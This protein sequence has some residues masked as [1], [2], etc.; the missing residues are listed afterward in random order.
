[1]SSESVSIDDA[2]PNREGGLEDREHSDGRDWQSDLAVMDVQEYKQHRRQHRIFEVRED[3]EEQADHAFA[4]YSMGEINRHGKNTL[5]LKAVKKFI[6]EVYQLLRQYEDSRAEGQKSYLHRAEGQNILGQIEMN[7]SDNIIFE[8]LYD[9]VHADP[10][11][12]E[13][14]QETVQQRHGVNKTETYVRENSVPEEISWRAYIL[15]NEFLADHYGQILQTEALED[16][17]PEWGFTQLADDD[18]EDGADLPDDV[19]VL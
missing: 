8:G 6:R 3:V 13:R 14:W 1:M 19:E 15:T 16:K 11:Y 9:V 7:H 4:L 10:T 17:L 5:I 12:T 18:G 2:P